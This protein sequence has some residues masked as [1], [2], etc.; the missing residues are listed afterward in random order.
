LAGDAYLPDELAG[1]QTAHHVARYAFALPE[2]AGREVVDLCAGSGYG[3]FVLAGA[4][5]S[6][7]A[8]ERGSE[9]VR[10][11]R[12]HHF[13]EAVEWRE[14]DVAEATGSYEAAVAFGCIE[15]VPDDQGFLRRA[16]RLLRESGAL[17]G[18]VPYRETPGAN[19][20]HPHADYDEGRIGALLARAGFSSW[21]L[22]RQDAEGIVDG[23][24]S[25]ATLLFV[26]RKGA[27]PSTAA[28]LPAE[29]AA[30]LSYSCVVPAYN[31]ETTLAESL[32]SVLGQRYPGPM[33]V[34]VVDDGSTDGTFGLATDQF[35]DRV[36]LARN[37]RNRGVSATKNVGLALASG[38]FLSFLGSDDLLLPGYAA[39]LS[40]Y[41]RLLP[42]RPFLYTTYD[43]ID[44]R[45]TVT[46]RYDAPG[47]EHPDD[48]AAHVLAL[49]QR[50]TMSVNY[51]SL[52]ARR[53]DWLAA[54]FW[55]ELRYGED[56]E[57]L[58]RLVLVDRARFHRIPLPLVR[59]R[60]HG[61]NTTSQ[62]L[63]EIHANNDRTRARIVQELG[64]PLFCMDT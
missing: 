33:E 55:E 5:R 25:P 1:P 43:F 40:S 16:Y 15:R 38:R 49:A 54:P 23:D 58:L 64:R 53:E 31:A 2:V 9:A 57:H 7:V 11:A 13:H 35:G 34:I 60:V 47:L 30:A 63:H 48:F 19:P 4:A 56:L 10:Y 6:V 20:P 14:Q 37:D 3:S 61:R 51:S 59:Y 36:I 50:D 26:A 41:A 22:H 32:E 44:A 17:V 24:K 27:G 21:E 12:R 45:G 18:S 39:L 42:D 62:R 29:T 28:E 8:V 46:A 52:F